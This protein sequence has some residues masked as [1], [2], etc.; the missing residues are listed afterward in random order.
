MAVGLYWDHSTG[1][2]AGG[3]RRLP[4]DGQSWSGCSAGPCI[5]VT[6][7]RLSFGGSLLTLASTVVIHGQT[8]RCPEQGWVC[9]QFCDHPLRSTWSCESDP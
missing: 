6:D 4:D 7:S 9:F 3:N 2:Q 1:G 5:G 8:G